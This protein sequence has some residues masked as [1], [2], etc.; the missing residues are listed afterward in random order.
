MTDTSYKNNWGI[1]D[2]MEH[3]WARSGNAGRGQFFGDMEQSIRH[4]GSGVEG[5]AGPTAELFGRFAR[6]MHTGQ[7]FDSMVNQVPGAQVIMP[8]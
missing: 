1:M 8:D 5:F 2:H 3:A 6:G 7:W 4:G